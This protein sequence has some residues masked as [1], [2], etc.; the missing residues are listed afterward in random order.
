MQC[1]LGNAYEAAGCNTQLTVNASRYI[2]DEAA[3]VDPAS[4]QWR[5]LQEIIAEIGAANAEFQQEAS[6]AGPRFSAILQRVEEL[7]KQL[8]SADGQ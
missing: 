1:E 6:T 7:R 4:P 2:S 8:Q 5:E 3:K